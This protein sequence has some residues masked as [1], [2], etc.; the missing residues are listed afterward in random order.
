M[1]KTVGPVALITGIVV[2]TLALI[3][4]RMAE[5]GDIP[6]RPT[7]FFFILLMLI[8]VPIG[9]A[10]LFLINQYA[11]D[12]LNDLFKNGS[13]S[14]LI[15]IALIF[16][17]FL[18]VT[19]VCMAVRPTDGFL[20]AGIMTTS[21]SGSGSGSGSYIDPLIARI[22]DSEART[23]ALM[24]RTDKFI[25]GAVG[26]KGMRTNAEGDTEE[27]PEHQAYVK[28]AQVKARAAVPGGII[29]CEN[30]STVTDTG[31]RIS[32]LNNTLR[33]FVGANV[34]PNYDATVNSKIACKKTPIPC[35]DV[36]NVKQEDILTKLARFDQKTMLWNQSNPTLDTAE[37]AIS[38]YESNILAPMD[39]L[40]DRLQK[41]QLLECERK[42]ATS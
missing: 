26:P 39:T 42:N 18:L 41:G 37:S 19:L 32:I 30:P 2:L 14:L 24:T 21:G 20:D 3:A 29:D 7:S 40:T 28:E 15:L 1:D 13:K 27:T 33:Y 8:F 22:A 36:K 6:I 35:Y 38:C 17:V 23:C 4:P 11:S 16:C 9:L 12:P 34:V 25:A 5:P 31:A 10:G